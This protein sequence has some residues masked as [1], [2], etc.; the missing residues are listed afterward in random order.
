MSLYRNLLKLGH[1][2]TR[3]LL[4]HFNNFASLL[5]ENGFHMLGVSETWLGEQLPS[6]LVHIDGF[7]F[8]RQDRVGRRGGGVGL[9]VK[10]VFG[11]RSVN[12]D[13][14][15]P[16]SIEF[17]VIEINV[18]NFKFLVGII[19][20]SP[21]SNLKMFTDF[22]DN[23]LSLLLT[24]HEHILI[25]G[26][27]NIDHT[28][29]NPLADTFN[30][31]NFNQI[32]QEATRITSHSEK[33]IDI[34]YTNFPDQIGNSGTL[35][36]DLISDHRLTYCNVKVFIIKDPPKFITFRDFKNMNHDSFLD[37]LANVKWDNLLYI[38]N[39]DSKVEYLTSNMIDLF[40]RHAPFTTKQITK[41]YAPWL[42]YN[43]KCI[44]R[45]RDL[46]LQKFK[47]SKS[48]PDWEH[49]RQLRNHAVSAIKN[50]KKAYLTH[51]TKSNDDKVLWK[52]IKQFHTRQVSNSDIPTNLQ[53]VN[54]INNFFLSV[55]DKSAI[56]P[57]ALEAYHRSL[58]NR[59]LKCSIRLPSINEVQSIINKLSSNATGADGINAKMI[60]MCCP[61]IT[62]YITHIINYCLEG[63]IFPTLW[64]QVLV[65]PLAKIH[66]P[67]DY[68]DL[69]PVSII[70][71]LSKILEKA[72]FT[73]LMDY[74]TI[75]NILPQSQ[76][77]FR[78]GFSTTSSL[79]NLLDNVIKARDSDL[80][81]A[82]ILLDFSKAFDTINHSMLLAKLKYI[83]LDN[84]L[85]NFFSNYLNG[86]SQR[87]LLKN[88]ISNVGMV[89]SGVP[90][91]SVL[92]PLLYLIYT[93]DL[94]R[95]VRHSNIYSFADDTQL[96]YSFN[97]NSVR[98]A[99]TF[100]N[101]DLLNIEKFSANH[102]LKLNPRK[103]SL[104]I[105]CG[106]SA[107]GTIENNLKIYL[108][109]SLLN[110]TKSVKILGVTFEND[111]RF[112]THVSSVIKKCYSSLRLLYNNYNILN[113]KLRKKLCES[114]VMSI[115]QYAFI[116]Y[117]P[118]LD[119]EYKLKIQKI[120]NW[121]C[122][123]V[124]KLRKFDHVSLNI[125]MLK[126]LKIDILY[127]YLIAN[128][129]HRILTTSQPAYL[130]SKF[131]R[132]L[133]LHDLGLR[134]TNMY[135]LPLFRKT[136]FTRCFRFNAIKIYNSLPPTLKPL[137]VNRFRLKSKVYYRNL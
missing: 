60:K 105:F 13:V 81:T 82:L 34:I 67:I 85:L 101:E 120:Q 129:V 112:K 61:L 20:R 111:L 90:Q 63:G 40:D 131:V 128:F 134:N 45:R 122:R 16:D 42:T 54:E 87:V 124:C 27:V 126:W 48:N 51:C 26:D 24:T 66:E 62:P 92:G 68:S 57:E 25:M 52:A 10:D 15:C 39:L 100:L 89:T 84:I 80:N 22:C 38:Q 73:Q 41:A 116:L 18:N 44:M 69:R 8:F 14:L 78:K 76:S 23:L 64:K 31:Y 11:A 12:V 2:N 56:E 119:T 65:R 113:F 4:A 71:T 5:I 70:T 9:Y 1:I 3:S 110:P 114:L 107:E 30:S 132:R 106:K 117:Y 108:M 91:G 21:N 123:F 103:C 37:D 121:C 75:N 58:L 7:K 102:K 32:I 136:L 19:Y 17:V 72:I 97:I 28:I 49:Y 135:S 59:N 115:I 77:G 96:S 33:I 50:E 98:E 93:F 133:S 79:I 53:Q 125:K 104:L 74:V 94:E 95:C 55:F 43:I 127:K 130:R 137:S 86:R 88:E 35:I 36:A 99:N 109:N 46:A 118:C 47:K 83:G 29:Q 6:N